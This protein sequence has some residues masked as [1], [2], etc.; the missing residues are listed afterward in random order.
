MTIERLKST[1]PHLVLGA[2]AL[3]PSVACAGDWHIIPRFQVEETYTDN[4]LL[5]KSGEEGDLITT[6]TPGF[7]LRGESGRVKSNIDYNR[8]ERFFA[9][10]SEFD[11]GNNQ[12]Q[13][14]MASTLVKNWLFF[15]TASRMSQQNID[16]RRNFSRINRGNNANLVDVTS[17]E[18]APRME[19]TFGSVANMNLRYSHQT[20]TRNDALSRSNN[21]LDVAAGDSDEDSFQLDMRSG[22]RAGRF[23]VGFSAQSRKVEYTN[24]RIN[25]FKSVSTDVSYVFSRAFRLTSRAGYEDNSFGLH[26]GATNGA[27]WGVGGTWTPSDRTELKADWGDQFFGKSLNLTATHRFRRLHFD[28]SYNTGARTANEFERGLLLVPLFDASGAPVFD[29]VT[30]GQILVP[31]TSPGVLDDVFIERRISSQVVYAM[32]RT[33]LS[34]SYF[35]TAREFQSDGRN[36][37]TRGIAFN[38]NHRIRPRLRANFGAEWR[39]NRE[40]KVVNSAS[41]GTYYSIFPSLS[42]DL[43]PHTTAALRYNYVVNNHGD[44]FG[45]LLDPTQSAYTENAITASLILHL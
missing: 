24:G 25:K 7:S 22:P 44:G 30:S 10:K 5:R 19:H 23:P 16:D 39:Q 13:A 15:D 43:G 37:L 32:R 20:V 41:S 38:V 14:D 40:S 12:L 9:D 35:Q 36:E 31:S 1:L 34:A 11:G 27:T 33:D 3:A 17:Y 4:V 8:Q 28:F 21:A 2:L 26:R 6:V 45:T 18:V 42:Y 29:P